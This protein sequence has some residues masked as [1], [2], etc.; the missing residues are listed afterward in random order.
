[1]AVWFI[2]YPV[3]VALSSLPITFSG[4]GIREYLFVMFSA[5]VGIDNN[6]M[7]IVVSILILLSL[8][9]QSVL[10][11]LMYNLIGNK[12]DVQKMKWRFGKG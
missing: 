11:A 8:L 9:S 6:E 7:A 12:I 4:L 3:I 5:M 2:V 1:M 10:G